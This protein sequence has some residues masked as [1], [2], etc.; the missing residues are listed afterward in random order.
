MEGIF[1]MNHPTLL[2]TWPKHVDYP[3]FRY[4]L[5]R[6]RKHLYD[7]YIGISPSNIEPNIY[8]F[9]REAT[10][11]KIVNPPPGVSDDWRD[12]NVKDLV[13]CITATYALFIE[14]DFLIKNDI[15][16]EKLFNKP[17]NIDFVYY[18]EGERIHPAFVYVKRD[19]IQ[20]TSHDF[21]ARPP[22]HDH[23]GKF[24]EE[25]MKVANPKELREL[26]L[27]EKEDFYHLGGLTQ[28]YYNFLHGEQFYKIPDFLAYNH[29]CQLLPIEQNESFNKMQ[30][31]IEDKYGSGDKDGFLKDF[32]PKMSSKI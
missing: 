18:Q 15:F 6:F 32:F 22:A 9:I 20:F 16:F 23:F 19:L 11:E 17:N 26:G 10:K 21:S 24:F 12:N 27:I 3:L 14:Q 2:T 1:Y 29:H 7:V 30:K 28:N 25:L 4:N 5:K 13:F 8:E 31:Q